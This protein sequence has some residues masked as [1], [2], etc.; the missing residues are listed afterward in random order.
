MAT[1]TMTILESTAPKK[2]TNNSASISP[3]GGPSV[4]NLTLSPPD[5]VFQPTRS[6]IGVIAKVTLHNVHPSRHRP[7][8]YKIKTNAPARYSVKPVLG[9]LAPGAMMD[10]LVRSEAAIQPEDRFLL[11][12]IALTDDEAS[13]MDSE[14]WRTLDRSRMIDTFI[15]CK[16]STRPRA[17]SSSSQKVLETTTTSTTSS[18][19]SSASI[20]QPGSLSQ[21]RV[22]KV[23]LAVFSI[24]CLLLGV[25]L[26]YTR[27]LMLLLSI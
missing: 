25:V 24:F 13:N 15:F 4:A 9:V 19:L 27:S 12:T 6:Q 11:Q 1:A 2:M 7:V 5:L 22:T 14:K 17:I 16:Q 26:P 3:N 8:A 21:V 18:L 23:D 20:R 10:V